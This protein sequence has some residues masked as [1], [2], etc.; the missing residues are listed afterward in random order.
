MDI[1]PS[2][3]VVWVMLKGRPDALPAWFFPSG[4]SERDAPLAKGLLPLVASSTAAVREELARVGWPDADRV[5]VGFDSYERVAQQ[6]GW[7]YF[8]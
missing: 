3:L 1:D 8:R 6:G 4:D 5:D 7:Q 2:H